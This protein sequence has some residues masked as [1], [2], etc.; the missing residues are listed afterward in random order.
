MN[1]TLMLDLSFLSITRENDNEYLVGNGDDY[2]SIPEVGAKIIKLFDGTRTVKNV[3]ALIKEKENI[4]VDVEDFIKDLESVGFLE[5]T[6]VKKNIFDRIKPSTVSWLFSMPI[7]FI[8][9][10]LLSL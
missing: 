3:T 6:L 4:E 9:L 2:I 5:K 8:S 7:Y 10:I 1:N